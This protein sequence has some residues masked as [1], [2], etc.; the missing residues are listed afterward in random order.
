MK[1]LSILLLLTISIIFISCSRPADE[2]RSE[3][4]PIGEHVFTPDEIKTMLL[5]NGI[6]ANFSLT[7]ARY[8]APTLSWVEKQYTDKLTK[9][10]FD[11]N[12][13]HWSRESS[14]CD[15]I[16]R[17]AAVQASILFHNS[18][19]RP[20]GVGL[21]FG[22]YHYFKEGV[23]GHAMNIAIVKDGV[24]YKLFF[25]EPQVKHEARTSEAERTAT[26]WG[27]F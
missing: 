8:V 27:R 12:L 24:D 7:D 16:S 23:G 20:K 19:N 25:Y 18:K 15:D 26:I 21:L 5:T 13:H 22:E 2:L 6:W 17:A 14:D 10:L 9:F 3:T 11:Y 4:V 1:S